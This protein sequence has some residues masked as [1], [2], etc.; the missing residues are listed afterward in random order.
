MNVIGVTGLPCSGKSRAA[1]LIAE[2]G[3]DGEPSLLLKADDIGHAVLIRPEVAEAIR[4]RLGEAAGDTADP[5]AMRRA[6]AAR[7]FRDAEELRWLEQLTHPLIRDVT[8]RRIAAA[9]GGRVV[10]ESALLF[11]GGLDRLCRRVLVVEAAFP[12]RLARARERGWDESELRRR[13]ARQPPL[14]AGADRAI[15][16]RVDNNGSVG[17]LRDALRA[18][19][20]RR[21]PVQTTAK[22]TP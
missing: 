13:E 15:V 20:D 16:A 11:A 19:L 18:A 14:P 21:N 5:A 1:A 10:L 3:V 6:I 2:G 7:V 8:L 9:G 12:V 17:M 22:G 4:A